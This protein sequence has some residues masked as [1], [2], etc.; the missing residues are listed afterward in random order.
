MTET[1]F[2]GLRVPSVLLMEDET[3][4]QTL[5]LGTPFLELDDHP[6]G[7]FPGS[8]EQRK[9]DDTLRIAHRKDLLGAVS[10]KDRRHGVSRARQFEG[11]SR[12]VANRVRGV[13]HRKVAFPPWRFLTARRMEGR[14]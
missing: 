13:A 8:R 3:A 5:R 14:I 4:G 9:E 1:G 12:P 6:L 2:G 11:N 7:R 10:T